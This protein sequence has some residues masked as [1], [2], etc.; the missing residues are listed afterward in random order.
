MGCTRSS[1]S[2]SPQAWVSSTSETLPGRRSSPASRRIGW[3]SSGAGVS[4]ASGTVTSARRPRVASRS[5]AGVPLA[6]TRSMVSAITGR[7]S[8][9]QPTPDRDV[10]GRHVGSGVGGVVGRRGPGA[11]RRP[12]SSRPPGP[13]GPRSARRRGGWCAWTGP[14]APPAARRTGARTSAAWRRPAPDSPSRTRC[15][16]RETSSSRPSRSRP[17]GACSTRSRELQVR[18]RQV[19]PSRIRTPC[20]SATSS[21]VRAS[22]RPTR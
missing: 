3:V 15:G 9:Q 8:R 5:G 12:G 19:R 2:R 1:Q 17:A 21:G 13:A 16:L 6:A 4:A 20:G 10:V 11:A 7:G 22:T 18:P 14:G